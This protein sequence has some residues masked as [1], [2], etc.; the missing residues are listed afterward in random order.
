MGRPLGLLR[1]P[2]G[3]AAQCGRA[4][5]SLR[6][7]SSAGLW[8]LRQAQQLF[9][10]CCPRPLRQRFAKMGDGSPGAL[11]GGTTLVWPAQGAASFSL[12]SSGRAPALGSRRAR[13][14]SG[15]WQ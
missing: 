4:S 2:P 8:G 15:G 5:R 10:Q 3:S 9:P 1:R 13:A 7:S 14:E 6:V 12:V 11:G